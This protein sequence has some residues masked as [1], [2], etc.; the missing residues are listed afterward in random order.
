MLTVQPKFSSYAVPKEISFKSGIDDDFSG[1]KSEDFYK[2]KVNYYKRKAAEFADM[3]NDTSNPD[4]LKKMMKGFGIISEALLEGWAV[5]WGT[6]KGAKI[7][8]SS[9]VSGYNSKFVKSAKKVLK[10]LNNGF[11]ASKDK[12]NEVIKETANSKTARKFKIFVHKMSKNPVGKY[13]V[14]G[15]AYAEKA[16]KYVWGL[17]TDNYGKLT[18]LLKGKSRGEIYDKATKVASSTL[19]VGAGVAGAYNAA[20]GADKR[21][22]KNEIDN[23]IEDENEDYNLIDEDDE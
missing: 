5:A 17:I 8:K 20:T 7:L 14:A 22:A 9:I 6:S 19:G 23:E 18:E 2:E 1:P 3:S 4:F 16:L 15:F 11:K 12:L 10:P 21:N 13:I